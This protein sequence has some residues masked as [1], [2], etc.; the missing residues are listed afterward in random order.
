M[1]LVL[2]DAL[3]ARPASVLVRVS[4]QF[5]ATIVVRKGDLVANAKSILEVLRLQ[6]AAGDEIEL[7]VSGA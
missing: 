6:A 7:E 2:A 5:D 1:K 4:T 3:H